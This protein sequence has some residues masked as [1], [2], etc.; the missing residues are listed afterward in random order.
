MLW[1]LF[2]SFFK[3]GFISF[4][5]GYAM[6]PVIEQEVLAHQW[7]TEAQYAEGVALAGMSPGPIATNSAV[8]VGYYTAGITGSVF[9]TLGII[10][11]SV[12]VIVLISAFFYKLHEHKQVKSAFY[13]LRPIIVAL[14]LFAAFRLAITNPVLREFSWDMMIMGLMILA[15]FVGMLRYHMHPLTIILLSGL[16]GIAIYS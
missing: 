13:G 16:V 10:L 4:G 1:E 5:G 14:I 6:I 11:P 3:I 8:Y 9:A 7:M 12:I 2:W 15:S